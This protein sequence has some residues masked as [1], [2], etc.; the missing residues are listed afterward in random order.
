MIVAIKPVAAARPPSKSLNLK[1]Y[2]AATSAPSST[3]HTS[4]KVFAAGA[5]LTPTHPMIAPLAAYLK[6]STTY[7]LLFHWNWLDLKTSR[8]EWLI[9]PQ[10]IRA[11]RVLVAKLL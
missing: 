11:A 6:K 10:K 3:Q 9:T 2:A 1:K 5:I 8:S 4:A 7:G